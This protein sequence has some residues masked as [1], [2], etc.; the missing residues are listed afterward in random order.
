MILYEIRNGV[1]VKVAECQP[2]YI[3]EIGVSR[4][5]RIQRLLGRT[6]HWIIPKN[7]E[8]TFTAA[9]TCGRSYDSQNQ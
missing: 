4:F 8:S 3:A 5:L 7:F 2:N 6:M 1:E 9:V